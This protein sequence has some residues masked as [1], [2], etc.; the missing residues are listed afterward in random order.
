M[1][2]LPKVI[3]LMAT[4]NGDRYISEQ[5]DSI[6]NQTYSNWQLWIRD[7]CSTDNTLNIINRYISKDNRIKI[8]HN[9]GNR[10]GACL[11]FAKLMDSA[12]NEQYIMFSDQD[13]VWQKTKIAGTLESMLESEKTFGQFVPI[14]VHTDF[15]I[16]D[17]YLKV[18][19][20]KKNIA[21]IFSKHPDAILNK[22]VSQNYIYGCTMMINHSLL[23]H[24]LPF[25]KEA[26]NHDYWIA[27]VAASTGQIVYL[28]NKSMLYRQHSSNVTIGIKASSFYNRIKRIVIN[29]YNTLDLNKRRI[30]QV[31]AL[32]SHLENKNLINN[33]NTFLKEF[34]L[35]IKR[36][37]INAFLFAYNNN[38]RRQGLIQTLIYFLILLRIKNVDK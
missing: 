15:E 9:E 13:D 36:G 14:L 21:Y 28:S 17:E 29:W 26:E 7:D 22:L 3:I 8:L 12:R 31:K 2:N 6:I 18:I 37:R 10:L 32:L 38:I 34:L 25:Y 5:L 16:V 4:F 24:C 35:N 33:K 19:K 30:I 23:K 27:L 1:E 20:T 11:N